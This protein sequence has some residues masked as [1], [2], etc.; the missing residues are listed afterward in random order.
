[1]AWTLEHIEGAET[2]DVDDWGLSN[3]RRDLVS[4][5][6]D[7]LTFVETGGA[8]D[9]A[10]L[11][12]F[13]DTVV[14][15]R[16]AT[17]EFRG[18]IASARRVALPE[19]E[20][21]EYVVA[22][23]W[24]W[25]EQITYQ[26]VWHRANIS[27][28]VLVGLVEE[29]SSRIVIGQDEDG[30]KIGTAAE[31]T[32][33]VQ[34]AIDNG[35]EIAIGTIDADV[36][37]PYQEVVDV[38]VAELI[39]T[40]LR[41]TP[42]A[43]AWFDYT[44]ATPTLHI[45]R[46]ANLTAVTLG[47]NPDLARELDIRSREDLQVP[48]V[49]IHYEQSNTADGQ[50][51]AVASTDVKPV[52][53]TGSEPRALVATIDLEGSNSTREVQQLETAAIDASSKAFWKKHYPAIKDYADG[54]LTI[55]SPQILHNNG[56][57]WAASSMTRYVVS[58]AIQD[59]MNVNSEVVDVFAKITYDTTANPPPGPEFDDLPVNI[60]LLGTDTSRT[61]FSRLTSFTAGESAPVGLAQALLD[62]LGTLHWQGAFEVS[63]SE[64][65]G[66]ATPGNLLR[67][68][69]GLAAWSTMDAIIQQV[70]EDIDAGETRLTFGPP[71][72]LSPQDLVEL[73]RANRSARSSWRLNERSTAE[74]GA[75]GTSEGAQLTAKVNAGFAPGG[76]GG[77]SGDEYVMKICENGSSVFKTFYVKPAP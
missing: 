67:L 48:A 66:V 2:R 11:F 8:F 32:A 64:V 47:I 27:V 71:E 61:T 10:P 54:D 18:R 58:G 69:G 77:S 40:C 39:R 35:A 16:D 12:A 56:T 13:D 17:I 46:R 57:S 73:L 14:L 42:D 7:S 49:A 62:A 45:R 43:A 74:K 22:G 59:W 30:A 70:S 9:T 24:S 50:T 76:G 36:T 20:A 60:Q 65:T 3:L 68:T 31:M 28:G 75:A 41:W 15:R 37:I 52:S 72:H 33:A 51:Y 6:A 63:E 25:L 34:W 55:T 1:M 44:T 19:G 26:Q 4:Q 53:A 38:T 5:G 23:P 21:R 29:R